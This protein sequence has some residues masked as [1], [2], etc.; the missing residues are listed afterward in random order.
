MNRRL[1]VCL[2]VLAGAGLL[3]FLAT[4]RAP[5]E[6]GPNATEKRLQTLTKR[7]E[8]LESRVQ[9]LEQRSATMA[10]PSWSPVPPAGWGGAARPWVACGA[11]SRP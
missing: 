4:V 11:A 6:D 10:V 1:A 3:P 5:A 8:V 2:L 7:V 9:S